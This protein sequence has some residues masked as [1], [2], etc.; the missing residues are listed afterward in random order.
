MKYC[1]NLED[2]IKA[3]KAFFAAELRKLNTLIQISAD[4]TANG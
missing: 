4:L 3:N 2:I 1:F